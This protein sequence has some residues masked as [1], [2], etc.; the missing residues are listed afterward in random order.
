MGTAVPKASVL[1]TTYNHEKY[2]ARALDSVL[3]QRTSHDCEIVV[4][5]DCSTDGTRDILRDYQQ[6]YPDRVRLL[7]RE[8]NVGPFR[9]GSEAL[10]ACRGEYVAGLEGDDYWTSPDKL[11]KQVD[12]LDSHPGCALCF[13]NA[14]IVYED[15]SREPHPYRAQQKDFSTIHDLF[16]D[17]YIPTAAVM[18]RRQLLETLPP[19]IGSLKMADWPMHIICAQSGTAG[20]MDE[21]MSAYLVRSGSAWSTKDWRDHEPAI[22]GMFEALAEN[23]DGRYAGTLHTILRWRNLALCEKYEYA[24]DPLNAR[25]RAVRALAEHLQVVCSGGADAGKYLPDH[26]N[27]V[28]AARLVKKVLRLSLEPLLQPH[29]LLYRM[30]RMTARAL[31]LNN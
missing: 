6:R 23:L 9:N 12:F 1:I 27:G 31:G 10:A 19:W 5:E 16:L 20:Y 2:I 4:G 3:M 28:K 14:L 15:G 26:M 18:F 29:P 8:K 21:I 17:N 24:G 13:H 25:K 11:Q 7:L 22:I 30:C